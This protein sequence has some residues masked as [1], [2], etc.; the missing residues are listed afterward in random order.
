MIPYPHIDPVLLALGPLKVRWYGIAYVA[1]FLAA[2]WLAKR[3]AAQ[4]GSTWKLVDVEDLI[5]FAV[6]GVVLGGRLGYLLFYG[7]EQLSREPSYWYKVWQGGMSFHGGLIGVIIAVSL[8]AYRRRRSIGDVLDFAAPIPGI[9]ILAGRIANFV[10]GELWG[11]ATDVAWGFAVPTEGGTVVLHATQLYE[12]ALEGLLMFIILWTFTSKPRPR[13]VPTGLFLTLYA[14]FRVLVEFVRVPDE[15]I[16][17]L[18]GGW[19]TM[20]IVLS[21]PMLIA[22]LSMI[23]WGYVRGTPSG[24]VLPVTVG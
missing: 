15:Q 24:N 9:G 10:N 20:G 14:V 17:Y 19:L 12:G 16:G 2:W 1:G 8:F 22:G 13:W 4:P 23:A 6:F 11:K 5:F 3:R 7:Q 18:A 21:V